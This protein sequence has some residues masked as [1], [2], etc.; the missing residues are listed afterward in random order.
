MNSKTT[1]M[2]LMTLV[3]MVLVAGVT[4]CCDND[5][6]DEGGNSGD[7]N[8]ELPVCAPYQEQENW[9]GS[10]D[11]SSVYR[12]FRA[13]ANDE[14]IVTAKAYVEGDRITV[15][16]STFALSFQWLRKDAAHSFTDK[17]TVHVY[18]DLMFE[19]ED[20]CESQTLFVLNESRELMLGYMEN[21]IFFLNQLGRTGIEARTEWEEACKYRTGERPGEGIVDWDWVYGLSLA[22]SFDGVG[23]SADFP[24]VTSFSEN[25]LFEVNVPVG[26][27]G[28]IAYNDDEILWYTHTLIEFAKV[29]E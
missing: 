29:V 10:L 26:Y 4:A 9:I 25:G 17:Q 21:Y 13:E 27:F 16:N 19:G 14:G 12:E 28:Q 7:H 24:A 3:T 20:C 1:L 22:G 8:S 2:L 18:L 11:V 15:G 23:F 6:K 5:E